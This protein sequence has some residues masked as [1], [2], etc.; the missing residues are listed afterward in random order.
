MRSHIV[1][2]QNLSRLRESDHLGTEY[3]EV[4]LFINLTYPAVMLLAI[5]LKR[6]LFPM[7]TITIYACCILPLLGNFKCLNYYSHLIVFKAKTNTKYGRRKNKQ[8]YRHDYHLLKINK[9]EHII[10]F[11][12]FH[13]F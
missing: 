1:G 3:K 10:F 4:K 2:R 8:N 11:V 12:S 7:I 9:T 13:I 5:A 6:S